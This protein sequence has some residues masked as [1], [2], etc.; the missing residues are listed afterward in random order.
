[1]KVVGTATRR[2]QAP[3]WRCPHDPSEAS[4]PP[5]TRQAALPA[6]P[7]RQSQPPSRRLSEPPEIQS[8]S[9]GTARRPT[10][11]SVIKARLP[12]GIDA[13][14]RRVERDA[15]PKVTTHVATRRAAADPSRPTAISAPAGLLQESRRH[16]FF[17]QSE[18]PLFLSLAGVDPMS[19]TKSRAARLT[20]T[21]SG[22]P[23]ALRSN[24]VL[25]ATR[26]PFEPVPQ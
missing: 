7:N 19:S 12:R 17:G 5:A 4:T 10:R 25:P 22:D 6:L 15:V 13:A 18:L 2:L 26:Q 23:A 8:I 21:R 11:Y 16:T 24:C 14:H 9:T 3:V 1:M 20:P